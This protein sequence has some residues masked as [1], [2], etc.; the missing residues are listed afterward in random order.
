MNVCPLR[1]IGSLMKPIKMDTASLKLIGELMIQ[2]STLSIYA[3]SLKL[4]RE[5]IIQ[6]YSFNL[7]TLMMMQTKGISSR[8]D[9]G[10]DYHKEHLPPLSIKGYRSSYSP[11]EPEQH[12]SSHNLLTQWDAGEKLL[13]TPLFRKEST[14]ELTAKTSWKPSSPFSNVHFRNT[15]KFAAQVL[16][17]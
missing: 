12:E 9:C 15:T 8:K 17:S 14:S 3:Y 6:V 1:L 16:C 7:C 5:P 13:Q 2:L 10:K 11:P 4:I